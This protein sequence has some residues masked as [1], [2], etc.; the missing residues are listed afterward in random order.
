MQVDAV[1]AVGAVGGYEKGL[2]EIADGV[3]GYLQPDGTWGWSNAGLVVGDDESVLVDTLFDLQ[4]TRTMLDTMAP[5]TADNP[6]ANV[7]N[8]HA[9]GDHCYGNQLVAGPGV[10]II[11]SAAATSEM[12]DVPPALLAAMV[13]GAGDD[14][15]GT[16]IT[17]A[18]GSF[19]FVGIEMP[20]ITVGFTDR[21]VLHAGG[22]E[23]ELLE[24]GPAHTEGDVLAWLPNERVVFAGDIL[25]RLGTPIM[26]AG[27]VGGWIKAIDTMVALE[28]EVIVPGHGPLTDIAGA[29]EQRGYLE[30]LQSLVAERHAGG[31]SVADAICDIDRHLDDTPYSEWSD[32]ERVVVNV[33]TIWKEL[34]SSF[35]TPGVLEV[36]QMMADN[37]ASRSHQH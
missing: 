27:P 32:R 15:L 18:F 36:F 19:D 3:F 22:R 30:L 1:G 12:A 24:V 26:W 13:E 23:V 2:V 14:V 20:E 16:Y 17:H 31:M 10:D 28:P 25:F 35:T 5:H 37:F 9:N 34:D 6:I 33:Q 7:V 11:A 29:L 8:T 21:H 4:L